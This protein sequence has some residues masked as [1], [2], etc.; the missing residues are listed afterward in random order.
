MCAHCVLSSL[1]HHEP[2]ASHTLPPA[3]VRIGELL[4]KR[5]VKPASVMVQWGHQTVPGLPGV[6]SKGDFR[7]AMLQLFAD[8]CD[9]HFAAPP[10]PHAP[11]VGPA[12]A[13]CS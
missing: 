6:L 2:V 11:P 12:R 5:M 10:L 4:R 8:R 3:Q 7:H 9:P 1:S 13:D